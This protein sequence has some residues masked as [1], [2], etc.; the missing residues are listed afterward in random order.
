[1]SKMKNV[2]SME[3]ARNGID[4]NEYD[5][6][7]LEKIMYA[8]LAGAVL[9]FVGYVFY[10]HYVISGILALGGLFYPKMQRKKMQKP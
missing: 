8:V 1:M 10:Q 4:Y 6:S 9:F 2:E 7:I 5:M 3:E